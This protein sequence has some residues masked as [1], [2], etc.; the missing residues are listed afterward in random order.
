MNKPL[1]VIPH[2]I[3]KE[4]LTKL[5]SSEQ[6]LLDQQLINMLEER[7]YLISHQGGESSYFDSLNQTI[8]GNYLYQLRDCIW[9]SNINEPYRKLTDPRDPIKVAHGII[10]RAMFR[11]INL[12]ND[13][14]RPNAPTVICKNG[15]YFRNLWVDDGIKPSNNTDISVWLDHLKMMMQGDMK[16]VNYLVDHLAYR[17]QKPCIT[18]KPHIAFYLYGHRHGCGKGLLSNTIKRV[19]GESSVQ[20][21]SEEN[22]LRDKSSVDWFRRTWLIAG[23]VKGK[24]GSGLIATMKERI[25]ASVTTAPKKNKDNQRFEIPA[26]VIMLSNHAPSFIEEQDRRWFISR[27][28]PTPAVQDDELQDHLDRLISWL[29][30][31]GYAR[32][33]KHL[34]ERDVSHIKLTERAMV[35]DEKREACAKASDIVAKEIELTVKRNPEQ[36][37]FMPSD[38]E[39]LFRENEINVNQY[40]HKM[41]SGDH[42]VMCKNE[43]YQLGKDREFLVLYLRKGYQII[44]VKGQPPVLRN[45]FDRSL[46]E[47]LYLDKDFIRYFESRRDKAPHQY[48]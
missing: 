41:T 40:K 26:Q 23:D 36:I 19:F 44:R 8:K 46:D 42:L 3:Q 27:F 45:N 2:P 12:S 11:S 37:V 6:R 34:R 38:F 9:N 43:R 14:Y 10:D 33:A 32:I 17:M 47:Y 24:M 13:Y 28:E 21:V 7:F 35:T 16:K 25:G 20:L 48:R 5:N 1:K 22:D 29:E 30:N 39:D 18:T 4:P 15:I 31:D